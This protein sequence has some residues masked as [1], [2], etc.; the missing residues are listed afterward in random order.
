M[1]EPIDATTQKEKTE[2]EMKELYETSMRSLQEGNIL[3]AR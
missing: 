2:E 1:V 3:W